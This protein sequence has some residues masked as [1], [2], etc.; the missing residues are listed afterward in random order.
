[1]NNKV[2][3]GDF[4]P[5]ESL[6]KD[7]VVKFIEYWNKKIDAV[8]QQSTKDAKMEQQVRTVEF[9]ANNTLK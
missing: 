3:A 2:R 9:I 7:F 4:G 5:T 8:K 1:M 6:A